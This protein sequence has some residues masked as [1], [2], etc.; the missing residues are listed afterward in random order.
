MK[1]FDGSLSHTSSK[2]KLE[3]EIGA[4][5]STTPRESQGLVTLPTFVVSDMFRGGLSIGLDNAARAAVEEVVMSGDDVQVVIH[6]ELRT[7]YPTSMFNLGI[8]FTSHLISSS[9]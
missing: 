9:F 7:N 1:S 4:I 6:K 2:T 5:Y 3:W 8:S